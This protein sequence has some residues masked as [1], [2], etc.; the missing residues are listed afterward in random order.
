M[1][2]PGKAGAARCQGGKSYGA[3]GEGTCR[4][5]KAGRM[6]VPY[7]LP[8]DC[9]LLTRHTIAAHALADTQFFIYD[10]VRCVEVY[11]RGERAVGE[12]LAEDGKIQVKGVLVPRPGRKD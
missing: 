1:A 12:R 6:A 2:K 3:L 8:D 5:G 10:T 4:S 9:G 11:D 7:G